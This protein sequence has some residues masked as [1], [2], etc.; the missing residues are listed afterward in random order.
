MSL[1]LDPLES[2]KKGPTWKQD[3]SLSHT[4]THKNTHKSLLFLVRYTFLPRRACK[5]FNCELSYVGDNPPAS[6]LPCFADS[7]RMNHGNRSSPKATETKRSSASRVIWEELH[8]LR[9]VSSVPERR[10]KTNQNDFG[11][12]R[13]Q[14]TLARFFERSLDRN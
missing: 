6:L 11:L 8:V 3:L 10:E 7:W 4:L 14:F 9:V 12:T 2:H 13:G 1:K 5:T